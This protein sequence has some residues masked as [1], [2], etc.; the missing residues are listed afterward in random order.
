MGGSGIKVI[1]VARSVYRFSQK[2]KPGAGGQ[3]RHAFFDAFAQRVHQSKLMQK[4]CLR[5]ALAAG[6]HHAVERALQV[7]CLT[8]FEAFRSKRFKLFL[9]LDEGPLKS[10]DS[11]SH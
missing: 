1:Q 6:K 8:D 11:N 3:H 5:G 9:V 2:D 4:L 7:G 10:Q